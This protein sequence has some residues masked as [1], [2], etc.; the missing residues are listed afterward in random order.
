MNN[1]DVIV[2]FQSPAEIT[3]LVSK[4]T[5]TRYRF[6]RKAATMVYIHTG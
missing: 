5:F 3:L 2:G 4:Q 6:N 1:S